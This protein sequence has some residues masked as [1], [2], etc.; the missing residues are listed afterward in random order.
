MKKKVIDFIILSIKDK[1]HLLQFEL[2]S[3]KKEK[4]TLT[5]SS[6]GDKFETSRSSMQIEYDK[7]YNQF[8]ILKNQG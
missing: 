8:I 3:I 7:I 6:A 5:K 4:N 2:D 1:I